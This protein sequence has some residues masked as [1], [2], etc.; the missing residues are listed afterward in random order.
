MNRSQDIPVV[1]KASLWGEG[2]EMEFNHHQKKKPK[3]AF[4]D[5]YRCFPHH[6]QILSTFLPDWAPQLCK[7]LYNPIKK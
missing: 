3:P 1:N 5:C 4:P 6:F 7:L 2:M